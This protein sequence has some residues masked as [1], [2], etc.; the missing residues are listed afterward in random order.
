MIK[1]VVSITCVY[2]ELSYVCHHSGTQRK[3]STLSANASW[4]GAYLLP[5]MDKKNFMVFIFSVF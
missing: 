2:I 5:N 3:Y 4:T 1:Y